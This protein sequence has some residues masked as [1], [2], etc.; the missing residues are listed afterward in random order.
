M[1]AERMTRSRWEKHDLLVASC[2]HIFEPSSNE[3]GAD[4]EIMMRLLICEN[5]S[6][7]WCV[8]G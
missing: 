8:K 3:F 4:E 1:Y 5:L 2:L 7:G 6:V